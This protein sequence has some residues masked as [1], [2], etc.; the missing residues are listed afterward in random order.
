VLGNTLQNQI[1]LLRSRGF[2][3]VRVHTDPQCA[4][5]SLTTKFENVVIDTGGSGDYVPKVDIQIRRIKVMIR[6]IKA[7]LPW[8]LPSFLLRGLVAFSIFRINIK[9]S[10]AVNWIVYARVA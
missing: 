3:L 6:G 4:L 8:R 5:R 9:R 10:T 7:T 2:C 1:E